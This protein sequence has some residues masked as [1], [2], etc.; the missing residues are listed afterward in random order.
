MTAWAETKRHDPDEG[1]QATGVCETPCSC[2]SGCEA[3]LVDE[4]PGDDVKKGE[5]KSEPVL[6]RTMMNNAT[7]CKPEK[8]T[9]VWS[10]DST[11]GGEGGWGCGPRWVVRVSGVE[12]GGRY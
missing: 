9:C 3:I 6:T 11:S 4:D 1:L 5:D 7:T 10:T 8:Q 12:N 2:L